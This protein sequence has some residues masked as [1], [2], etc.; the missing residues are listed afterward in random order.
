MKTGEERILRVLPFVA[1]AA[2]A[3][4]AAM[5]M[6]TLPEI[7]FELTLRQAVTNSPQSKV[8]SSEMK[9]F[10]VDEK[11]GRT[12][13]VW[14]GHP[15]CGDGFTVTAELTPTP[16]KDGWAYSF[17]YAGNESGLH[18]RDI[19]FPAVTVSRTDTTELFLPRDCG[20]IRRPDWKKAKGGADVGKNGIHGI[21]FM[22]AL[23]GTGESWYMDQRG[24]ARL[25]MN[26]FLV[27][28]GT[29]PHPLTM[30]FHYTAQLTDGNRVAGEM[31][32]GVI[33]ARSWCLI[34]K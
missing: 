27:R 6:P 2:L 4:A 8:A 10:R 5:A 30:L 23:N 24:D 18:I 33:P 34:E 15:L 9:S 13:L 25:H 12:S 11:D 28:N 32:S 19:W 29:K 17:R 21:H 1:I 16:E 3:S 14:R 31:P 26:R 20:M 7:G 22:A